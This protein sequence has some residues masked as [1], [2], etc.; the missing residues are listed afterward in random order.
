[1]LL[2]DSETICPIYVYPAHLKNLALLTTYPMK[3]GLKIFNTFLNSV[4]L[5]DHLVFMGVIKLSWIKF[6]SSAYTL[7]S[8]KKKF[9][10]Y[11]N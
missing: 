7:K 2:A 9:E 6:T 5:I 3:M 1:M 8:T 4:Y 10:S 11:V